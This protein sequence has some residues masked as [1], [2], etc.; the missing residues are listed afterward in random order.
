MAI[1]ANSPVFD[2]LDAAEIE[3]W[4]RIPA[5]IAGDSMNRQQI[6]ASRIKPLV[7]GMSITGQARTVDAFEGDNSAIHAVLTMVE[8]GDVLVINAGG[9]VNRALW[10]GILNTVGAG[11]GLVG[12]VIDGAV[13]D[14]AEL[15]EGPVPVFAAGVSPAG[16]SKGWGGVIDGPVS[17]GGVAIH[18]GDIIRADEDGIAVIPL[19][20]HE[21]IRTTAEQRLAFEE[22]VMK[23]L[24]AGEDTASIFGVPEIEKR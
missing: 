16:P 2:R 5:A 14:L 7:D 17:C 15:R 4:S 3:A 12:V 24:E 21:E 19:A 10:G 11:K 18:P 22:D 13:R 20:R 9:W 1:I 6:M 23:R 8:P